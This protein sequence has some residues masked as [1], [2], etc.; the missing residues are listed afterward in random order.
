MFDRSGYHR[1]SSPNQYH[2]R[3]ENARFDVVE[4]QVGGNLSDDVADCEDGVDLV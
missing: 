4:C 3:K 1:Q 2:A